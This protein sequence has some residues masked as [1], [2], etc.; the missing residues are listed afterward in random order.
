MINLIGEF[1]ALIH[2]QFST[3]N[4]FSGAVMGGA[5]LGAFHYLRS[6][7]GKLYGWLLERFCVIV[8]FDSTDNVYQYIQMWLHHEVQF[9]RFKKHYRIISQKKH[10]TPSSLD[11]C[12]EQQDNNKEEDKLEFLFT[13]YSG[14]YIF[15][16]HGKWLKI[17]FEREDK[18]GAGSQNMNFGRPLD[19][20]TI[21][22][23]G[24]NTKYAKEFLDEITR[25]YKVRTIK[26]V[27]TYVPGPSG[28][29]WDRHSRLISRQKESL[30]LKGEDIDVLIKDIT[31]FKDKNTEQW[32]IEKGIPYHRGYLFYGP[33]GTGKS[34][35]AYILASHFHMD[36]YFLN[37]SKTLTDNDFLSLVTNVDSHSFLVIED[38]DCLF[39]KDRESKDDK[40]VSFNTVLNAL[41]GF[42]SKHGNVVIMTTNH[43]ERL[44][45][46]LIRYGRIDLKIMFDYFDH[47]QLERMF[48]KFFP[49]ETASAKL[50]AKSLKTNK[51][52]GA[53]IQEY[54]MRHRHDVQTA[55]TQASQI[56][57]IL[58]ETK[59]EWQKSKSIKKNRTKK[60][61][62]RKR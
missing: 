1:G 14:H 21:K 48:L 13:P 59:D 50:F 22:Y 44:D 54:L 15:K 33:P 58:G 3:N 51:Y 36:I 61:S 60:R 7:P 56:D 18:N 62:T 43:L 35:T 41:D 24:R 28:S 5:L 53:Q 10:P 8:Y 19:K 26:D 52:S 30:V 39:N 46:A 12:D 37:V 27:H 6:Y 42:C 23:L 32:Y 45:N 2:K 16:Y 9:D 20:L 4:F 34:S 17:V 11:D 57:T 38:V 40:R 55:L 25:L 49:N 31:T 47:K 29:Y